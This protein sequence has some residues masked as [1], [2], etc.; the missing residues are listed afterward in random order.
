[1][2]PPPA[3]HTVVD[4][5]AH[6]PIRTPYMFPNE[7]NRNGFDDEEE[8]DVPEVTINA[9][10][11][12]RGHGNIITVPQLDSARIAGMV[13]CVLNGGPPS[14][15]T[16]AAAAAAA[17]VQSQT[18]TPPQSNSSD[19]GNSNNN[20]SDNQSNNNNN[21]TPQTAPATARRIAKPFP[22][23]NVTIN[24]G[25]TVVGDRNIVGPGLGDIARQMQLQAHQRQQLQQQQ[26]AATA[27]AQAQSA[28][29]AAATAASRPLF[30]THGFPTPPMSRSSSGSSTAEGGGAGVKRKAEGDAGVQQ[31]QPEVKKGNFRGA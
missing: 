10:T 25:A 13:V 15:T 14:P 3:Y 31:Q 22:R 28:R 18:A 19:D 8:N 7:D 29:I 6:I 30:Q 27:A 20:N 11:Q 1:M 26:A 21:Q 23:I 17:T 4:S 24:C 12:I 9:T 16:T 2:P 5:D